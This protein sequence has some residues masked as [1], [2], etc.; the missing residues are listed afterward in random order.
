[1][2]TL[3]KCG[4]WLVS[5]AVIHSPVRLAS[6]LREEIQHITL[7]H[8]DNGSPW[9]FTCALSIQSLFPLNQLIKSR[10]TVSGTST[11]SIKKAD[12]SPSKKKIYALHF[13]ISSKILY[14]ACTVESVC[15][16]INWLIFFTNFYPWHDDAAWLR[17]CYIFFEW[18]VP[19]KVNIHPFLS[20][21]GNVLF[22]PPPPQFVLVLP[23]HSSWLA[24]YLEAAHSRRLSWPEFIKPP[25]D[26]GAGWKIQLLC[27][28]KWN[29][30]LALMLPLLMSCSWGPNVELCCTI[31]FIAFLRHSCYEQACGQE[32]H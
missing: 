4:T 21:T 23:Q 14:P 32:R 3:L 17:T 6:V 24:V 18:T 26:M 12:L 19:L 7:S 15:S 28:K 30:R 1:M 25:K 13:K 8:R 20:Q 31:V 2:F 5:L 22:V 29:W 16:A 11:I 10:V 9:S 27:N